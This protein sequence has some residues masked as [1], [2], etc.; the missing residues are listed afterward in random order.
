MGALGPGGGG[1]DAGLRQRL[2]LGA[3]VLHLAGV[4]AA[5]LGGDAEDHL[6]GT[7]GLT[8]EE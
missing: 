2:Q 3:A 6:I 8:A 4:V 7:V 5:T 1:G